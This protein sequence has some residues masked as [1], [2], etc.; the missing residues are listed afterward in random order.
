VGNDGEQIVADSSTSTGLRYT[1]GTVQSNPVLNSAFQLWQRGTSI[2]Y[3]G[4][5]QYTA[6]R[7]CFGSGALGR[8]VSRQVTGDTT[9][10]PNIQYCARVQ[11]DSG[12]TSTADIKLN[13]SFETINSIPF[14]GRTVT[15][16][17]YARRG[18]NFSGASN[19]LFAYLKQ[20]TG[21]DQNVDV[22]YTGISDVAANG[23]A[24]TTTW[25]RFT[26]SGTVNTASTELAIL[27]SYTPVGTAGAADFF[28]VTGVQVDVG[29]VA[30]PFR[31]YAG[32]LQGE[33][34]ACQRYYYQRSSLPGGA[35]SST[36]GRIFS[37]HPVTMRVNPTITYPATL[38]NA[39]EAV[40]IGNATPTALSTAESGTNYLHFNA[41]G[42]SGFS[43]GVPL[44]Y[45][46]SEILFSSEL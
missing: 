40:G 21:T 45:Q 15:F 32:T 19:N 12:N 27:F 11:R 26:V 4:G 30:L 18:A 25:Q 39:L 23:F 29:S 36:A 31:T 34:A 8:T 43:T 10:L 3:A 13:Q 5:N 1:S 7:W 35:Y 37:V 24:L 17:F 41:T 6:D 22:T 14:A 33:L 38:T 28:E 16:S 9:N 42:A 2:P 20:G 44:R 46:G